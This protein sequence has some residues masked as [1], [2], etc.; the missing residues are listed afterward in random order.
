MEIRVPRQKTEDPEV[1]A[2]EKGSISPAV[3][4]PQDKALRVATA[5]VPGEEGE[6]G[7]EPA[8]PEVTRAVATEVTEGR[9]SPAPSRE[10]AFFMRVEAGAGRKTTSISPLP[11]DRVWAATE[12]STRV[13]TA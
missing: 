10:R 7:E 6:G 9:G 13:E 11:G 8:E 12:D 5:S 2:T 3:V 1:V 4:G